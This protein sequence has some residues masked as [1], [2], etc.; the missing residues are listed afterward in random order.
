MAFLADEL[1]YHRTG[2]FPSSQELEISRSG[3]ICGLEGRELHE[4]RNGDPEEFM[5]SLLLAG[6]EDGI[7]HKKDCQVCQP[8]PRPL[9][10]SV[11]LETD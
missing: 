10:L 5:D 4:G 8:L 11:L 9:D 6:F 7:Q 1:F 3:F 2:K